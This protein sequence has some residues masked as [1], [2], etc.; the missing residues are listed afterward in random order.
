MTIYYDEIKDC[1]V[2]KWNV[3]DSIAYAEFK[4]YNEALNYFNN[5]IKGTS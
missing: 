4:T 5:F 2:L 1:F 3:Q